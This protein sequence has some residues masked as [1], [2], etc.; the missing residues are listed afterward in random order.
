MVEKPQLIPTGPEPYGL[1]SRIHPSYFIIYLGTF[2]FF[3]F[4]SWFPEC[5]KKPKNLIILKRE[6]PAKM[7]DSAAKNILQSMILSIILSIILYTGNAFQIDV[8]LPL[9]LETLPH[10][11]ERMKE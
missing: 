8:H 9:N 7:Q 4:V 11:V 10:R 6:N 3:R 2:H 1:S 5:P